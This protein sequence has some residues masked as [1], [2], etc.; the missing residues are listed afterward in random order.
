MPTTRSQDAPRKRATARRA[1]SGISFEDMAARRAERLVNLVICLLSTR[2]FLTAERIRMAVPGYETS[3]GTARTDEAFKR[4][5]ERDK[6]ELRDLGVPLETGRNSA[7]D[8]EDGYRITR[9]AYELP[10]V[11]FDAA[12][13]AAVGLAARLWQSATLGTPARNALIKLR[14]GGTD[15]DITGPP[16]A[17]PHIDASDPSLPPLLE[18]ARNSRPV[19]FDYLKVGSSLP[20]RRTIEPWGVLSWRRRWYVV[21][22]DR[23]RGEPRSFRL[24]R[25]T[26]DVEVF[27]AP[28]SFQ[29][30]ADIDL[31]GYV[32]QRAPDQRTPARIRVTGSRAGQL[33]RLA[34]SEQDGVLSITYSDVG[35]L[36]RTVASAGTSA[37]VLDPPELIDAVVSRLSASA[38]PPARA[39]AAT[40][41]APAAGTPLSAS[42]SASASAS[43]STSASASA[44]TAAKA[45]G[46][47]SAGPS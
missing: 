35:W 4:M 39:L 33:R 28:G 32:A 13:A 15:I 37:Q 24:S 7:F 22:N 29:R 10:P 12:E 43:L 14:A 30:P 9:R 8:G 45:P 17:V 40:A 36:A 23:D 18:A 3:D 2:Q 26:G 19:R 20:E 5:F 44:A 27:A 21:G 41:V 42:A 34:T 38:G 47:A 6:A 1:R 11:S 46:G 25:I 31:L 16:G